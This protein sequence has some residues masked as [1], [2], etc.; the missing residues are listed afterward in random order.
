VPAPVHDGLV[1]GLGLILALMAIIVILQNR[2]PVAQAIRRAAARANGRFQS[3]AR[4]LADLWHF[5]ATLYIGAIY[6]VWAIPVAGGAK[7]MLRATVATIVILVLART[8]SSLLRRS[9]NRAFALSQEVKTRFPMLEPRA[10]RYLPVLHATLRALVAIVTVLALL[11]AWGLE[12]MN[13]IVS[14]IGRRLLA[15]LISIGA[16]IVGTVLVWELVNGT[17]ERYMAQTATDGRQIALSARARTLLPLARSVLLI[18]IMVMATLIV[19][20]ELG[21]NIA[22]LLAGAGIIGVAIGFGSQKLVQDVITGAFIL[23]EDTIAVGDVVNLGSHGGV[24]EALS[25]R[26]IRLRDIQG[27]LH[28][29]PFSAVGTVINMSRDFAYALFDIGIAYGADADRVMG[30]IEDL[31]RDMAEDSE[32]GSQILAPLEMMGLD[33]FDASSVVIRARFKT[34]AMKQWAVGREFNRR[35]KRRFDDLGIEIPFPQMTVWMANPAPAPV[36]AEPAPGV[37]PSPRAG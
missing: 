19:L 5:L 34:V 13:W 35:L 11:Q 9:I 20:S 31:G 26:A 33:R 10:N 23:F 21:V 2:Y 15:S 24:V 22:P 8:V 27:S 4:R 16:V 7:F 36:A 30:V 25:I 12:T 32:F 14:D 3:Y 37:P 17:I 29:V 1:K 18:V 28:T 6:A